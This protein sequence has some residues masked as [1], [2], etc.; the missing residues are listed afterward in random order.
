MFGLGF[1][2]VLIILVV[3]LL[4]FGSSK[5]PD[6]GKALGR[7]IREFKKAYQGEEEKKDNKNDGAGK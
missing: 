2:E 3:G 5:L 1:Q 6:V 7:S 4:L